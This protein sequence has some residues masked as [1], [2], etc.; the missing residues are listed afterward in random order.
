MKFLLLDFPIAGPCRDCRPVPEGLGAL[1]VI[2][3]ATLGGQVI[4]RYIQSALKI[5]ATNGGRF[6]AA[7][8]DRTG[9]LWRDF[10]RCSTATGRTAKLPHYREYGD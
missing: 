1:Y 8:G 5:D 7:Y 9:L 3:G 2:E 6:F 10:V 4:T